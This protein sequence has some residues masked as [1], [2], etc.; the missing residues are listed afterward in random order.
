MRRALVKK[1]IELM[2]EIAEDEAAYAD[3]Y[4]RHAQ[5]IKFG[6]HE[7]GGHN[8]E[9]I[10]S[11]LRFHS[12]ATIANGTGAAGQPA[13]PGGQT[14]LA[15]Y[16]SRMAPNQTEIYYIAGESLQAVRASP[17]LESLAARGLEVL[18]MVD[19]IDEYALQVRAHPD[20][21]L[22]PSPALALVPPP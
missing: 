5:E 18:F 4:R 19:P 15:D 14:S 10:A 12:T 7:E 13:E 1:A 16:V 6:V 17:F 11:L 3:F 21:D 9:R 2:A 20:P 8:R 22:A